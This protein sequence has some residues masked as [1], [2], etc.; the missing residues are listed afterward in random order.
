MYGKKY[1][2]NSL[3]VF[4]IYLYQTSQSC[5]DILIY[6]KYATHIEQCMDIFDT[7]LTDEGLCCTFNTVHPKYLLLR[8]E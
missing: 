5:K 8:P 7:S 1:L 2:F 6:C 4:H 3:I